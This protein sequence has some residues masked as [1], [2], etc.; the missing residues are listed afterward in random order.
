MVI[1]MSWL[2]WTSANSATTASWSTGRRRRTL[3]DSAAFFALCF[4]IKYR[5]VSGMTS[6]PK[7]SI[8]DHASCIA[9]GIR[10]DPVSFRFEVALLTTAARSRP[11]VIAH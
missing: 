10:Y 8:S 11:M 5:G 6:K 7:N 3:S 1:S 4:L 2:A 9:T